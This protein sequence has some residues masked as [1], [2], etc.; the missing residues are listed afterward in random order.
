[1]HGLTG[2]AHNFD[3]IAPFLA[4]HDHLMSLDVRGRGD[5]EW[6]PPGEY[7]IPHYVFDLKEM[8]GSAWLDRVTLIGTSMGGNHLDAAR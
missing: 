1:M 6:G 3:H 7:G 4:P 2:N 8:I 5:S